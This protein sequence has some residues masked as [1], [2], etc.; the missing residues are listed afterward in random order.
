MR[1]SINTVARIHE[2][3]KRKS[4]V[5]MLQTDKNVNVSCFTKDFIF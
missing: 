2:T 4:K 3:L 5:L 1:D